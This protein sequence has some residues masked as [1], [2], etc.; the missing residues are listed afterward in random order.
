M[1]TND[2][3]IFESAS[4]NKIRFTSIKGELTLEQVW[5]VPLR[6]TDGFNLDAVAQAAYIKVKNR[7]DASFVDQPKTKEDERNELALDIVKHIIAVKLNDE[8]RA[9]LI[10]A[11]KQEITALTELLDV[12]VK[13]EMT[14]DQIRKRLATLRKTTV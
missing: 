8:K 5:D 1:N 2:I 12:K 11:N 9:A 3:N 10:A 6:S 13:E 4:R 7:Q 14:P